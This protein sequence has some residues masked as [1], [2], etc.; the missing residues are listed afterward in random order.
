MTTNKQQFTSRQ[1][2]LGE[3]LERIVQIALTDGFYSDT[4]H[5]IE[6]KEGYTIWV[7]DLRS[8]KR[9][10]HSSTKADFEPSLVEFVTDYFA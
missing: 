3:K 10:A 9:V 8:Q 6:L 2:R 7:T 5:S 1:E 4:R